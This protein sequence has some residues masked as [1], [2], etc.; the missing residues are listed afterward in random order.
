[1]FTSI[2]QFEPLYPAQTNELEDIACEVVAVSSRLEGRLAPVV[3]TEIRKLLKIVNSYYSNLIEGHSTHPID[4]EKAMRND[5][6][7]D[8]DKRDLQLESLIHIK[9]QEKIS[10]I[11]RRE[12]KAD[13]VSANFLCWIHREFYEN[14]PDRLRWVTGP[15]GER[16]FVEAGQIRERTVAVGNHVPPLPDSLNKFL[17]RFE[18]VYNP[19]RWHGIRPIIALAAAHHRLMWI[20]PF[21]DGNGRVARL[22]TDAYFMRI[23]LAGYGLWNV[24]RGLARRRDDY[25]IYLSAADS[26]REGDLDGRGNL[27]DKTL[28]DFC[29]FFLEICLDQANFMNELLALNTFLDRLEK[30]VLFRNGGIIVNEKG[31]K[32][33]PLNPN[34]AIL[35]KSL[36]V[37][38]EITRGEAFGIIGMSERTGRNILKELL[39]EGLLVSNSEREPVRL[40]FPATV[41]NYWFPN[42][43]PDSIFRSPA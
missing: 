13:V 9:V 1:M 25:R 10:D 22:F 30:Y 16:A 11:L 34:V 19:D 6:S 27:S 28:T 23:N 36:A 2:H 12:S 42:L 3:L 17:S 29:R 21:L 26:F 20:H 33:S 41:A 8:Q 37:K 14:M 4:V 38:G 5:Y 18:D 7:D 43:Y 32:L 39:N 31:E 35:L 24:S 15:T 40:G